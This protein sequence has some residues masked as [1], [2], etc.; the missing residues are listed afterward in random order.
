MT[1]RVAGMM[2]LTAVLMAAA[3]TPSAAQVGTGRI[4]ATITDSTGAVLPGA[5]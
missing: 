5:G 3:A 1:V 2:V 4:D